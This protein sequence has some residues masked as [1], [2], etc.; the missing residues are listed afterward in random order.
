MTSRRDFLSKTILGSA[1][2]A[3][4]GSAMA[5]PASSYRRIIGANDRLNVA[6]AGLGRRVGA[7]Y[8]PIAKKE[9][10][11]RLLYLCDV[12][13]SQRERALE[14]FS[15]HINYKPD[16]ENDIRKVLDDKNVDVLI[17]ATP[18]HWHTPG[19]VMA[20][21]AGKDVYVEKP[22]SHDMNENEILV[23]A[24]KK[25]NKV[26][27]MGNQQRSSAHTIKI[28]NDIHNGVIGT[29]Y[30]AVA[31]Y[32]NSRGE[33]PVQKAAPVPDG[34]DW[35]LWQGPA[36]R[37]DYTHNTWDYNWHWYG[38]NYGTAEA[39]NNGT[40]EL[41]VA[42]WALGVDF[43]LYAEVE[44]AKR[45]FLQ[46]GWEMYDTMLASFKFKD[47]KVIQWDGK[48]RN[49]YNTYGADRGTIIY[50]SE[51]AVFVDRNKYKLTDRTGKVVEDFDSN[52]NEAGTALGG[53]GDMTTGHMIN[54][55]NTIRGKEK[56]NAPIDDASISMAMVHYTN[57]AY[58]IGKG[59]AIDDKS[60]RIYDREAMQLWS[61]TYASG[62]ELKL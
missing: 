52:N 40:H 18:D 10:N 56:L 35:E 30:K 43:P 16:L 8:E 32:I 26:V 25:Y 6:V 58:R 33:V 47:N 5:M 59:F 48:S 37:R 61:R 2:V 45:H 1:A 42:R 31:F 41:D 29:P 50:G 44:G 13:K 17:N 21:K 46:D 14:N 4:G 12:M 24:A 39:G 9:A 22:C 15:K 49:G 62:W 38:W 28:I 19:A 57:I 51:G 34:L 55:F 11:V 27:Q 36:I 60:G 23:A 7:Y 20:M 3:V 53:G 54:F